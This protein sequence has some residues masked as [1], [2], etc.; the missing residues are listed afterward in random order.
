ML[1]FNLIRY[2]SCSRSPVA[3]IRTA[4]IVPPSAT[5]IQLEIFVASRGLTCE[6]AI[7]S[8]RTTAAVC[9]YCRNVLGVC[10]Q[11]AD[12]SCLLGLAD[13]WGRKYHVTLLVFF[14]LMPS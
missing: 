5:T 4:P 11:K 8:Y 7:S 14:V 3:L 13:C 9:E 2:T 12:M 1:S 6:E 10:C